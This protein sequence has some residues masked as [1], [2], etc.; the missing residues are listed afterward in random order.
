[1]V[2]AAMD[3]LEA[4]RRLNLRQQIFFLALNDGVRMNR[5]LLWKLCHDYGHHFYK[6]LEACDVANAHKSTRV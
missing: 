3:E 4:D 5:T 1:M 2:G 6:E